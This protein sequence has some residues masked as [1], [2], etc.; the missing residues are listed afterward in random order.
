MY[1]FPFISNCSPILDLLSFLHDHS[2]YAV[3]QKKYVFIYDRDGVELHRLKS[4]L[5]PTQL[6]FLP[7]H[8]LLASIVRIFRPLLSA[9]ADTYTYRGMQDTLN[10]KIL[11]PAN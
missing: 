2:H 9:P 8:W 1:V 10:T 4:H 3:A 11:L 5:E 7:Y 6:E